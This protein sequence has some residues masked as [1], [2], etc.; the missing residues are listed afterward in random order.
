MSLRKHRTF[1]A[2]LKT[3]VALEAIKERKT[4]SALATA[5]EVTPTRISFWNNSDSSHLP[6]PSTAIKVHTLQACASPRCC[7]HVKSSSARMIEEGN[8][9][10]PILA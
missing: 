7:Q 5:H 1:T 2:K 8:W 10:H 4:L 3:R 6:R 9:T